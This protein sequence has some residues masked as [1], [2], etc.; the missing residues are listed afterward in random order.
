MFNIV[1][2]T[3]SGL[4]NKERLII[5]IDRLKNNELDHTFLGCESQTVGT[6]MMV[7]NKIFNIVGGLRLVVGRSRGSVQW[8][9]ARLS[10]C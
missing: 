1:Q 4:L 3:S 5:A 6:S 7:G 10:L 2:P 9:Q 8:L